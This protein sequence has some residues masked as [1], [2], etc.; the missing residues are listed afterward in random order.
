M[1]YQTGR[2]FKARLNQ[3]N[4]VDF[5]TGPPSSGS[6]DYKYLEVDKAAITLLVAERPSGQ[7]VLTIKAALVLSE[8][9][10]LYDGLLAGAPPGAEF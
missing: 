2:P 5:I 1:D 10:V 3:A 6:F 7:A 8:G 4:I 9:A